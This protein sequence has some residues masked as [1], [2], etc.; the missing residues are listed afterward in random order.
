MRLFL[1]R[2]AQSANNALPEHQRVE[3]PTLTELGHEQAAALGQ[4][5]ATASL[6]RVVT[7]P[8]RRSLETA[9]Y[10]HRAT[11]LV[12]DIWTELHEQGGCYAGWEPHAYEGRP[13]MSHEAISAE[14]PDWPI[15][16][17]IDH[18]GWWKS[19]PYETV[20][21]ARERA[22]SLIDRTRDAF[23]TSEESVA[24][25][26]HADFKRLLL[27]EL[28]SSS[29]VNLNDWPSGIYNTAVTCVELTPYSI[30]LDQY[31]STGHLPFA[32][33]SR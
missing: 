27:E 13:G 15:C 21:Q 1:I 19:R 23:A 22:R 11:G 29:L 18:T 20:E 32:M 25:V 5:L 30:H 33:Q 26:I 3:D 4:W 12:P 28:F 6:D 17:L 31:N 14:F 8:F 7:S 9:S 16:P 10:I 24:Y 2:H